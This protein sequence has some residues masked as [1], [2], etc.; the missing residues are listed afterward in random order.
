[1][2]HPDLPNGRGDPPPP[3]SPLSCS[4]PFASSQRLLEFNLCVQCYREE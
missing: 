4:F 3:R 2:S 1:M